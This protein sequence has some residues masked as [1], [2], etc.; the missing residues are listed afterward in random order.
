MKRLGS[1]TIESTLVEEE[2]HFVIR[3][4]MGSNA[5]HFYYDE[6]QKQPLRLLIAPL[7]KPRIY[8]QVYYMG[9]F[10]ST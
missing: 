4:N 10:P 8:R 7:N 6:E 5:P 1:E 3:L 2:L 9:E